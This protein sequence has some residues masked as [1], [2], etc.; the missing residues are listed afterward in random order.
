MWVYLRLIARPSLQRIHDVFVVHLGSPG[1]YAT[2]TASPCRHHS[3]VQHL[4][5]GSMAARGRLG[6]PCVTL[7]PAH[8][9]GSYAARRVISVDSDQRIIHVIVRYGRL[10]RLRCGCGDTCHRVSQAQFPALCAAFRRGRGCR[11]PGREAA[12]TTAVVYRVAQGMLAELRTEP[13]VTLTV[14]QIGSIALT[15]STTC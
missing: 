15:L 14:T 9:D 11:G 1:E 12:R 6:D 3:T 13:T 5:Q 4:V 7:P 10:Q 2:E 8:R